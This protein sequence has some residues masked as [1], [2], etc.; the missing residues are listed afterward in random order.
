MHDTA[1]EFGRAFFETYLPTNHSIILDVDSQD[2]NGSL[3]V[4]APVGST[5][6]GIDMAAGKNVDIVL[7]DPHIFPL[8]DQHFDAVVATS[9]FEHDPM[10][11]L[12]FLE[13]VRVTRR[14]GY[15]YISAPANGWYH[16]HPRDNWR[17]Y[18]DAGLSL[19][20]WARREGFDVELVESFTG[21]RKLDIWNDFV[22]VFGH[23]TSTAARGYISD[24]FPDVM[25][26]R[27]G[28]VEVSVANHTRGTEDQQIIQKLTRDVRQRDRGI[29][30]LVRLVEI[31]EDMLE[32]TQS[33]PGASPQQWPARC[34]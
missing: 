10:F 16:Q 1:F 8:P 4:C 31:F 6:I 25:N 18:P 34:L 7:A 20:D 11:W 26:L 21:R 22:M 28:N 17:F 2:I 30:D 5:Y 14:G 15:I 32:L 33:E 29:A 27:R 9:C 12:T 19:R 3:R 13:I 24:R 23:G